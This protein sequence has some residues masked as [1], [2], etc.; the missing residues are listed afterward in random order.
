MSF[1]K[2]N[3]PKKFVG[4]NP[5]KMLLKKKGKKKKKTTTT[6]TPK[7]GKEKEKNKEKKRL[8]YSVQ[9]FFLSLLPQFFSDRRKYIE[10]KKKPSS[11]KYR[12]EV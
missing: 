12:A 6:T 10:R 2:K 1:K 11:S 9:A 7:D 8:N 5:K 4:R 3:Q